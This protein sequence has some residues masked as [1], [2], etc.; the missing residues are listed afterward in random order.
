MRK[1]ILAARSGRECVRAAFLRTVEVRPRP[2][3]VP[4]RPRPRDELDPPGVEPFRTT[5]LGGSI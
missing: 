3:E 2:E 1:A 5:P 4:V